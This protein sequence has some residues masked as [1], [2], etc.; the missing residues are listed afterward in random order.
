V[1][2]VEVEMRFI[3]LAA[4]LM[5]MS[6]SAS[7]QVASASY[8]LLLKDDGHTWCGYA[9]MAEFTSEVNQL[10]PTESARVTY[11]PEKLTEFTYQV[12]PESGDWVVV[13]KYTPS[14]GE[15]IIMRA[16]LLA[17]DNLQ[18]I[19]ESSIREGNI[20]PFRIVSTTTL[21]GKTVTPPG[22][23]DLPSVP[24]NANISGLPFLAVAA[25]MRKQSIPKLCKA[26]Q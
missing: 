7:A 2:R 4:A 12:E 18:I 9:D 21:D 10:K 1:L 22:D 3:V 6:F 8:W 5:A 26:H 17:Q 16:N 11:S 24:V 19:Q 13:D 20:E 23:I 25:E 15:L 14:N